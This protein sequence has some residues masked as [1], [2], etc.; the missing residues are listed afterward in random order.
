MNPSIIV[1]PNAYK[2]GKLYSI[3]PTDGAGDL[4]VVRATSATRVNSNGLI[5]SVSSNIPRL[6]YSNGSCPSILVEPQRTNL[7][8]R[9]EEFEDSY[10]NKTLAS[11]NQNAI[12]SPKNDLTADEI[13]ST[14][15]NN[16]FFQISS[17]NITRSAT[18]YSQFF[19]FKNNNLSSSD[20]IQFAA[21]ISNATNECR[22]RLNPITMEFVSQTVN[23]DF[24]N[25]SYSVVPLKNNWFQVII[26]FTI[27]TSATVFLS[28]VTASISTGTIKSFYLWGA[29]LEAGSN[30]TSYIPTTSA[31]VTRNVDVISKTG[32][33]SLINSQEGCLFINIS[34]FVNGGLIRTISLSDGTNNNQ[35]AI[36]IHSSVNNIFGFFNISGVQFFN[37]ITSVNQTNF[38]KILIKW[39]PSSFSLFVNS[40]KVFENNSYPNVAT[41]LFNTLKFSR[42]DNARNIEG[43]IKSVLV[44]PTALTDQQCISLTTL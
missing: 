19:Y 6:D 17:S 29:Q 20:T 39:R 40:I 38:N 12:I 5:E 16:T 9:S 41:N 15:T 2:A 7:L 27:S 24:S 43:N 22:V 14:S 26:N 25:F 36:E 33:G 44:F 31:S 42:A 28:R 11:V 13:I 8:L 32:I 35:V 37:S 21:I 1:T 10:W 18:Q 30:A 23:G 3:V 4:N 34:A